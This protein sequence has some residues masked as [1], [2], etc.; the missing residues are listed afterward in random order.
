MKKKEFWAG[1]LTM[2][3]LISMVITVAAKSGTV[4]QELIY[5]NI[6]ITLNGQKLNL[7]DA[8][9]NSVEPF[10]F[11]G[12]NYLPVRA[13]S[14]ALGLNV[15]WD[16]NTST[17]VLTSKTD[18]QQTTPTTPNISYSRTNPAPIGTKQQV[19]VQKYWGSYTATVEIIDAFRGNIAWSKI[20]EAN[21]FNA[22]P[23]SSREYILAG[24]RVTIDSI[25]TDRAVNVSKYDFTAFDSTNAEYDRV[26]TV[27]PSPNLSGDIYEGGT[28]EG[29]V[30]FVVDTDD[31][32]PKVVYGANTNGSGGIWFSLVD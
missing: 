8:N 12:T 28:L 31:P 29:W 21:R 10:M 20:R 5:N 4:T 14:E 9:G 17:I 32:A 27:D 15:A 3:L 22:T 26:A 1:M 6:G 16:G 2:L 24:I 7:V 23:T 11:N 19:T 18:Q 30:S 13:I 25:S